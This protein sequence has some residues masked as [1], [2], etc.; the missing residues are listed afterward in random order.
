MTITCANRVRI[1][2]ADIDPVTIDEAARFIA[3]CAEAGRGGYVMTHNLEH[4]WLREHDPDFDRRSREADLVVADGMPLVLA[5]RIQRTPLPERVGGIDLFERLIEEAAERG[6][7]VYLVGGVGSVAGRAAALLQQR[8]PGLIIA[9]AHTPPDDLSGSDDLIAAEVDRVSAARPALVFVGLPSRLQANLAQ[10]FR[11]T[12]PA[13]WVQGVGVSFSFITG[14]V[15]RAP[16]WIQRLGL[17][18]LHRVAQQPTLS[19][20]YFIRCAP[21]GIRLV[22]ASIRSRF[23][24]S[25]APGSPQKPDAQ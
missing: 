21:L 15:A 17:E 16:V 23:T 19:R 12:L 24:R 6:L 7:P 11:H 2:P 25:G 22:L 9:G 20:R 3:D 10:Q 8:H 14:D 13:A 5:S 18:W 1:G 4:L